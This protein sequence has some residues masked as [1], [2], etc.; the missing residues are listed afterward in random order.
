MKKKPTVNLSDFEIR[1]LLDENGVKFIA[2]PRPVGLV[3]HP[4]PLDTLI[5]IIK[6]AIRLNAS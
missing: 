5:K 6:Q 3:S 1:Q 2:H 4:I